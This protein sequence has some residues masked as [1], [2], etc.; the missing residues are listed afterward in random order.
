MLNLGDVTRINT[1]KLQ[2]FDLLTAGFPCQS[3]SIAGKRK[4]FNE[5]R[6][7]LFFDVARILKDKKPKYFLLENVKGLLSHD[8]GGTFR[9][10]VKTLSEIGY[11]FSWA[12]LNSKDYGV[13]Q[14]RERV[15]IFGVR[16]EPA[17]E[18]LHNEVSDEVYTKPN[19]AKKGLYGIASTL[20]ARQFA[21]WNG[22]Y[23]RAVLTPDRKEKRQNG[24]R[25]KNNGEPSFTLT[26]QDRHG[27]YNGETIRKL[28][29]LECERLMG[30]PDNFSKFGL[31]NGEKK[32]ISDT[33]RYK[34]CGN[35][36]VVNVVEAIYKD[37]IK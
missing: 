35:G 37:M 4:G 30:L 11:N 12:V 14:N 31:F 15:F 26:A 1:K 7:T 8:A 20:T 16:G 3:F 13:P 29:P 23:V 33:Q 19:E 2:E 34:M 24:R 18:I 5:A 25:I 21:S 32:E 6:G 36:V 9:T 17:K 22:N 10:I 28:T 27:V